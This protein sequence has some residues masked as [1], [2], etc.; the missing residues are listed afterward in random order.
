MSDKAKIGKKDVLKFATLAED[1]GVKLSEIAS[2]AHDQMQSDLAE[3]YPDLHGYFADIITLNAAINSLANLVAV[4]I[5]AQKDE[6]AIDHM[7]QVKEIL[8]ERVSEL[9]GSDGGKAILIKIPSVDE[10]NEME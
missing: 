8:H 7:N 9:I 5:A 3:E 4:A 2:L 6:P 10:V 1:L